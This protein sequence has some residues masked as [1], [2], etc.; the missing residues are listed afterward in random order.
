MRLF[1]RCGV[2]FGALFTGSSIVHHV[3]QPDLTVRPQEPAPAAAASAGTAEPP[4]GFIP[5]ASFG[6][7]KAGRMYKQ[8]SAGLGYYPDAKDCGR[9][10]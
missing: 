1:F 9:S 3:L 2:T 4:A 6:G 8:G 10:A 5:A 7:A